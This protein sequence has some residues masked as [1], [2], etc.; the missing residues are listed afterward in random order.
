MFDR[1]FLRRGMTAAVALASLVPVPLPPLPPLPVAPPVPVPVTVV[2][3][4][5]GSPS[6]S[7]SGQAAGPA[8]TGSTS[9]VDGATALA[10]L[11]DAPAD[12]ASPRAGQASSDGETANQGPGADRGKEPPAREYNRQQYLMTR[13]VEALDLSLDAEQAQFA[14]GGSGVFGWPENYRRLSQGFGCTQLSLAPTSSACPSGHFHTGDD[15]PGPDLADVLAADTGVVRVF[16]GETGYGNYLI[17]THG[18]GYSTLYGHLHDIVV[19]DGSLVQRGDLLAHEGSTG[20][21]TGPHL[22]FEVRQNG[23][24]LDPCPFLED[25]GKL[26]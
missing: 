11:R 6:A 15:I 1:A 16:R 23:Q 17:V 8:A 18:N 9:L 21:S 12:S 24:Y 10:G 20:N 2:N 22:H 14:G 7:A 13:Q 3:L 26:P 25:C 19:E 4:P 5:P